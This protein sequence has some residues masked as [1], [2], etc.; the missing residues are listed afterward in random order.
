MARAHRLLPAV[1][2][3]SA[4]RSPSSVSSMRTTWSSRRGP[5]W[6]SVHRAAPERRPHGGADRGSPGALPAGRLVTVT[7][8]DLGS[9]PILRRRPPAAWRSSARSPSPAPGPTARSSTSGRTS[10]AGCACAAWARAGT[11]LTIVHGEFLDPSGDVT[12][13]HLTPDFFG[14]DK[15]VGMIDRVVAAGTP[16][17]VF[18]P[19]Q[20][21]HGFQYARIE[22]HPGS[23]HTRRRHRRGRPHRPAPHGLVP[24]QRRTAQPAARHH[25]MVLPGQRLRDPDRLPPARA[26]RLDRGLA[27]VRP[28]RGV[29]LRRRRVLPQVAARPRRRTARRRPDHQLRRRTRCGS[30]R[31]HRCDGCRCR[32]RRGGATPS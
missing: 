26:G 2:T 9:L 10:M 32:G 20:T 21:T 28:D 13:D 16:G 1:R 6:E 15:Q 31:E 17:E 11:E 18:E 8:D 24:L 14:D 22:G 29:P 4:A 30:G 27:A 5:E 3:A 12:Q 7:D 23:A 25:G 19:R